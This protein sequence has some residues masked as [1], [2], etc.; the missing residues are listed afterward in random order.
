[1][2]KRLSLF[3]LRWLA[4]LWLSKVRVCPTRARVLGDHDDHCEHTIGVGGHTMTG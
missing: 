2:P 4:G 1:M 3:R